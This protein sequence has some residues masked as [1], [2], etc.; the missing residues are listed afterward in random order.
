VSAATP[1]TDGTGR[2][3]G[4]VALVTGGASGVGAGVVAR[5]IRAGASVVAVDVDADALKATAAG[6]DSG[7]LLTAVGDVTDR[8]QLEA[9][10][11]T[12][13]QQFGTVDT[14]AA[15]AGIAKSRNF[16]EMTDEDRD[17]VLA[18]NFLGVW[19]TARAALPDILASRAEGR[20]GRIVFCGSIESVLG[21][22]GM[23]AY[24]ASKHAVVGLA[25][26]LS[27]ELAPHGVTVN[28]IS[29][30][31]VD[32]PMLRRMLPPGAL[33]AFAASTPI[34]RLSMPDEV[35][36]FFEFVASEDAGYLTGE[37]IVVDGGTKLIN[38]HFVAMHGS[39]TNA[40]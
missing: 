14:V 31:G 24:V 32:T 15:V 33:D 4:R 23:T 1:G 29:P 28:V 27:L 30:A 26:S 7:R 25:K 39:A 37:N 10:L 34:A 11:A 18:V 2:L 40:G 6:D 21:S 22:A 12:A 19:N 13:R 38:S 8:G 36:A 17:A 3:A 35:A 9:A 20:P 5:F 16:A